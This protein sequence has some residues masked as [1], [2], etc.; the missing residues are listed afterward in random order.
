MS[1]EET[2][3]SASQKLKNR[4]CLWVRGLAEGD[5]LLHYPIRVGQREVA[6]LLPIEVSDAERVVAGFE[7]VER[8]GTKSSD[9]EDPFTIRSYLME[10]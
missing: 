7:H 2:S 6:L 5:V 9:A 1:I 4:N 8:S 3:S 10:R